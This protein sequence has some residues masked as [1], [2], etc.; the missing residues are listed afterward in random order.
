MGLL[1]SMI[2]ALLVFGVVV[3]FQHAIWLGCLAVIG[4][5]AVTALQVLF[6]RSLDDPGPGDMEGY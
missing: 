2:S 6:I 1:M 5:L 4:A 3:A